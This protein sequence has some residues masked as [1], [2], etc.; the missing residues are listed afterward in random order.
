ME[1]GVWLQMLRTVNDMGA[2]T[3]RV[4]FA[5]HLELISYSLASAL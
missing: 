3:R 5:T 4:A 2:R 1:V